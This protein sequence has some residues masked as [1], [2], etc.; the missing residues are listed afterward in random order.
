MKTAL[1]ISAACLL[2]TLLSCSRGVRWEETCKEGYNV[3]TQKRGR[4]L[5]YSPESGIKILQEN[6]YAFKDLDRDGELDIYEDWR[7]SCLERAQDLASKLSVE[8]IAGLM[9][10]SEHQAVPTDDS[11]YWG[12]TYNGTTLAESGLPRSAVSDKQKKFLSEDMLRAVL[13]VRSETPR[14]AAE[15]NNNLQKFCEG[16]GHGIPVNISSDPRHE[17]EARAEFNAGS[18]GVISLWPCQLGLA[19]TFDP[20]LVEQFGKIAS[21]EYRALGIATA[22]S[23]QADIATEP[24]WFRVYGTFG[25]NPELAADMTRAYVDGFQTSERKDEI[26]NGWGFGSVNAMVKH[27]PGGGAGEGGRD[28]HYSF[29]KYSVYPGNSFE[30]QLIP[31]TEGAFKLDGKTKRAS[32]VMPYYTVSYGIDPGGANVGNSYSRYII[33]DLLRSKAGYDGVVCTDWAITHDYYKVEEAN[34]KPW[35]AEHLTEG[36]R[37]FEVIK[38]GVDQFG[39]NNAKGPVLEAYRMW[40][41]EYGETSARKRFEESAVRLLMNMFRTGLFDNPY[42]DPEMT[43]KVVGCPEFMAAGYNAQLKSVVMLK[44]S[45]NVLPADKKMK[46]YFPK[47]HIGASRGF[48]GP[49]Q[50]NDRWEYP[51]DTALVAKYWELTDNPEEAD[52]ALVAIGEPFGPQGY[53]SADRENGGNGYIPI[54][55]QYGTY[56]AAWAREK[57]IAGGDPFEE[58][59][60]RSYKGK[61]VTVYNSADA[62]L[63]RDTRKKMGDKPVVVGISCLRPF[64]IGEIEPYADAILLGF[65][66]QNQAVL[67]IV[68]GRAEPSGLL[69]VQMPA[70]MRAVE[71]QCED[72]PF[73]MRCYRDREGNTYDFAFGLDWKGVI[74]DERVYRYRPAAAVTEYS[75]TALKGDTPLRYSEKVCL[76]SEKFDSV[77]TDMS[78][79]ALNETH[80]LIVIKDGKVIYE[81]YAPGEQAGYLHNQWSVSKAF[82]STAVGFAV[83][84]GLLTT[85]DRVV[86][87]FSRDELPEIQSERLKRIKVEHLLTMT[88]GLSKDYIAEIGAGV[89]EHP[90][91]EILSSPVE[92]EPGSKFEYNSC[93]S[94]LLS[95]IVTKVSGKTCADYL[96]EKLFSHLGINDYV[97]ETTEEGYNMGG[98]GLHLTTSAIA[99]LG[100]L[101]L[102]SGRWNGRQLLD[103]EWCRN[104]MSAKV[105][106]ENERSPQSRQGYGYQMWGCLDNAFRMD[107]VWGQFSIILPEKNAVIACNSHTVDSSS[108]LLDSIWKHIVPYI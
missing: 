37:H 20:D 108:K 88:S 25:E 69:P 61:T 36:Q 82:T 16:I 42:V 7:H 9:L 30:D 104:A 14:M 59:D 15:W 66:V 102:Q 80:S 40:A 83:Q 73:D 48:F 81:K 47:R 87:F 43:E 105:S 74:D 72:K 19:A 34:G 71:E 44:N 68:S 50:E 11:G 95:A 90:C 107:G 10:Y 91:R 18:G 32:A 101:Y 24:R 76:C 75:A 13:L 103:E 28:A 60:N 62:G 70:D 64:V 89:I 93:N 49:V 3:I 46:V 86:D 21:K 55:L 79:E 97:F 17:T 52:F 39:G 4:T 92:S 29:G 22:L 57:S 78:L 35:G 33:Q 98:W 5:G 99:K 12:S 63:V 56:T 41:E 94:Y 65:C 23:P 96:Q 51:M 106:T 6:G 58:S 54:S 85:E 53:D 84:D 38:A 27:W 1:K 67:D 8:E 2:L 45:G 77:F 26:E 100:L 31:F